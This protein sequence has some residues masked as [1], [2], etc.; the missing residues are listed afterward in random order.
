MT[1]ALLKFS[2]EKG[3]LTLGL[4]KCAF[5]QPGVKFLGQIVDRNG[6]RPDRDKVKA[7]QEMPPP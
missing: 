3:G 2:L 1:T 6:I 7:I 4:E 5:D